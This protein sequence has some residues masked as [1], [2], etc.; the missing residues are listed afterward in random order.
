VNISTYILIEE[1]K[2]TKPVFLLL[3]AYLLFAVFALQDYLPFVSLQFLIGLPGL[4]FALHCEKRGVRS[5]RYGWVALLF[6][7]LCCWLPVNT[8]LFFALSFTILF[9]LESSFGKTGP[10]PA[11]MVILLSPVFKYAIN[12]FSWPLRLQLTKIAG[13]VFSAAGIETITKGNV[14]IQGN[15]EFSIDPGC[16][17]LTMMAASLLFGAVVL[18]FFQ[19]KVKKTVKSRHL[20]LYFGLIILLNI[21]ANLFRIIILV[22]FS[23]PADSFIHDL[24][25]IVCLLPYVFYPSVRMAEY[26]I[27]KGIASVTVNDLNGKLNTGQLW[28]HNIILTFL[29][30]LAFYIANAD[31]YNLKG[32]I[33]GQVRD[34]ETSLY[35][36]GIIKLSSMHTLVYIK[37]IRGFY[38]TDHNPMICWVG[39]GFTL[40][41]TEARNIH[42]QEV[43]TAWLINGDQ[44]LYTA[45][46]YSNGKDA[47]T[48]QWNWRWNMLR[49]RESY[50]L[51][52]ITCSTP[53]S[54]KEE[55]KKLKERQ[56]LQLFIH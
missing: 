42:G 48:S 3:T 28:L 7:L 39:S 52:N 46:W 5:N 51:V 10:I 12:T 43:F 11:V 26:F 2:K 54:L 36:P 15:K 1:S 14:L 45:W 9:L 22:F 13:T 35:E 55:I 38:D 32:P 50:A 49:N 37:Q 56:I 41:H 47:T 17:G 44:K 53:A 34:Y 27:N 19:Q 33:G 25:G 23:I 24:A 21:V 31:T 29:I 30:A 4:C 40:D 8:F 20:F 18:A 16:M 6:M